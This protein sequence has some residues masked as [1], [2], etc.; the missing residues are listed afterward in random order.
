M[1]P[2]TIVTNKT[3]VV[4]KASV[5][6]LQ[7][8]LGSIFKKSTKK[9]SF[10]SISRSPPNPQQQKLLNQNRVTIIPLTII[11]LEPCALNG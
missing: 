6:I 4:G 3:L 9:F 8:L 2:T 7:D 1:A 11:P 10:K 5:E